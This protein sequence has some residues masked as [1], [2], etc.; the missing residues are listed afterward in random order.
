M[1]HEKLSKRLKKVSDHVPFG[2]IV[3]DIGSDHAY[4]AVYL[5]QSGKCPFV[6]A[7]EVNQGPLA[8]AKAHIRS[9]GLTDKIS[10]KLGNG[11]EVLE[12]ENVN[13][14]VIAGMGG[15]LIATIL[16]EGKERLSL[17]ERLI[18]Q[19]NVA[20]DHIRRWLL[21]NNWKLIDE[22]ILEEDSHV[23]EILVAE[24][25]SGLTPYDTEDLEK[26]LWLGPYLLKNKNTAFEKK[27]K[28][29]RQQI[30]KINQQLAL[31]GKN[32]LL[33]EKKQKLSQMMTWLEEEL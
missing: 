20:A 25:G 17:V 3:G 10:A 1:N 15:P 32:E 24:K 12:N 4:L 29:E 13:T 30:E 6:V 9:N 26:Q 16:E 14:V 18:L 8:S 22:E 5:I 31:S 23:Y 28:R 33:K 27:W 19:P 21:E 2:A 7:G 11:L